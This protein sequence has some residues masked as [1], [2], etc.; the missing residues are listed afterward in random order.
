V[1]QA[2]AQLRRM[3]QQGR[4]ALGS[5]PERLAMAT[6]WLTGRLRLTVSYQDIEWC[7]R[8]LQGRE[9][10]SEQAVLAHRRSARFESLVRAFIQSPEYVS[11]SGREPVRP[12][13]ERL[14]K[15]ASIVRRVLGPQGQLLDFHSAGLFSTA[16]CPSLA[17]P[18]PDPDAGL[19]QRVPEQQWGDAS[20]S[21]GPVPD[22]PCDL[23]LNTEAL[24]LG[25]LQARRKVQAFE[26]LLKPGTML[27][28]ATRT[29]AAGEQRL[30]AKEYLQT[31]GLRVV[32]TASLADDEQ[33]TLA[34]KP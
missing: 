9:P 1:P 29:S 26:S 3:G 28:L 8:F 11:T 18:S 10:E 5:W 32:E 16:V 23:G 24:D 31:L 25:D 12:E 19:A 14:V 7:Y 15:I 21:P 17:S 33:L 30:S 4:H 20:T 13:L 34:A 22:L 6:L 2:D 27:L